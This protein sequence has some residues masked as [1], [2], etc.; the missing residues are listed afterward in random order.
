MKIIA[1]N[2]SP[3]M[4]KS[5]TDRLLDPLLEGAA[6]AGAQLERIDV[7]KL[8]LKPCLGCYSCWLKTQESARNK[9]IGATRSANSPKPTWSSW[10]PPYIF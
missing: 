5:N 10:A 3:R 1:F 2:C 7:R 4:N 9:T 8:D 6:E